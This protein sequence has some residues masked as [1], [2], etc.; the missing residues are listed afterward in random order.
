MISPVGMETESIDCVGR[1]TGAMFV[2][3][4]SQNVCII[5]PIL[6]S[7]CLIKCFS[8]GLVVCWVTPKFLELLAVYLSVM[9][10]ITQ[11]YV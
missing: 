1:W 5:Q 10:V 9:L 6:H 3:I 8:S 2:S 11:Y 4:F 7:L